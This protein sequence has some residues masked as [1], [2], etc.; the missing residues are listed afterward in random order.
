MTVST[1]PRPSAK[2]IARFSLRRLAR[3]GA[4]A[5]GIK[6]LGAG[7]AYV[8]LLAVAQVMSGAQF[9]YFGAAFSLSSLLAP[10]CLFGQHSALLRFWPAYSIESIEKSR[11]ALAMSVAVSVVGVMVGVAGLLLGGAVVGGVWGPLS[12]AA[13]VL[14]VALAAAEFLSSALRAKGLILLALLPRDVIWRG[15]VIVL[16]G[17]AFADGMQLD[18]ALAVGIVGGILAAVVVPQAILVA[19]ELRKPRAESAGD[20]PAFMRT[21]AGLW[22]VT[23][24][25]SAMPHLTTLVVLAMLGPETAG[26]VFAAE[27]TANLISIGLIGLNQVVAPELS[28]AYHAGRMDELQRLASGTAVMASVIALAGLIGFVFLGEFALGLFDPA[29]ATST[30]LAVLLVLAVGQ[31]I[32]AGC[33]PNGWLLQMTGFHIQLLVAIM[34]ANLLGFLLIFPLTALN[35]AVGSSIA[36]AIVLASWNILATYA[37]KKYVG[38]DSSLRNAILSNSAF[39]R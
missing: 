16:A 12:Q 24:L 30:G 10:A 1:E 15:A 6:L 34:A 25:G 37:G 19:R 32:N 22:G 17:V 5:G 26:L 9:G 29:Y 39:H 38:V 23:S 2:S 8:M 28:R 11:G 31:M 27:R 33:G 13:A 20:R 4:L 21:S 18:A 36:V 7:L 14:V 35:G 3:A